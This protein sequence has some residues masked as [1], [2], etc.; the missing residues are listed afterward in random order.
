MS[1]LKA[2]SAE[3]PERCYI[4]DETTASDLD[5]SELTSE[6]FCHGCEQV[7]CDRH[8]AALWGPHD[9]EQHGEND[10]EAES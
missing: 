7:I 3:A 1:N 6:Y 5:K 10:E 8:G 9:P 2:A 4:C